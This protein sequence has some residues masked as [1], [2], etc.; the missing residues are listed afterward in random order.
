MSVWCVHHTCDIIR[1]SYKYT[2]I[3]VY[4][5]IYIFFKILH[6]CFQ[7]TFTW[8]TCRVLSSPMQ[9]FLLSSTKLL[10]LKQ[11]GI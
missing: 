5:Y 3:Y 8:L 6:K 2:Y 10:V 1:L 7:L 11:C 9:T 4:V